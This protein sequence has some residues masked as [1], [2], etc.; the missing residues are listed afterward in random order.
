MNALPNFIGMCASY[1][2][3]DKINVESS[4]LWEIEFGKEAERNALCC[5]AI[6]DRHQDL[7][8]IKVFFTKLKKIKA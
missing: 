6:D 1:N 5:D 7:D 4:S 8:T 2:T 3:R